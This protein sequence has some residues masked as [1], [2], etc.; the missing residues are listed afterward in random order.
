M[1]HKNTPFVSVLMPVYNGE[2]YIG[3]A[4][5]SILDQTYQNFE[6]IVINDNSTDNTAK[7]IKSYQ[8]QYPHKVKMISLRLQHGAFG[9]ANL[10]LKQAKGEFIMAMDSDDISHPDRMAKQVAFLLTHKEVIVVG[11]HS[12]LIDQDGRYIGKKNFPK[13]HQELYNMYFEVHP[14]VHPSCMFRRS[15]LPNYNKIYQDEYGVSDDY[16]TLF[17]LLN[18]GKF[19][20]IPETLFY[21]RIHLKNSSLQKLKSKLFVSVKIRLRAVK[22]FGYKPTFKGITKF[23]SQLMAISLMPEWMIYKLYFV[24]KGII[25]FREAFLALPFKIDFEFL[26]L[27]HNF[28]KPAKI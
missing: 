6:L 18:Y 17:T 24:S 9:A 3:E 5:Q 16:F 20:N 4:I 27:K 26:K 8:K 14:M 28:F 10:A 15:L 25:S 23:V 7:V 21:Y 1:K 19:A 12:D 13:D 22:D 11:S 2:K